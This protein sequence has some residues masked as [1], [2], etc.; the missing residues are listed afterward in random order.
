VVLFACIVVSGC[1]FAANDDLVSVAGS[2]LLK[3]KPVESGTIEFKYA[4][5]MTPPV[6]TL[7]ENGEFAT[8]L[9][10]G[11]T[12]V[13]ISSTVK[14]GERAEYYGAEDSPI[15]EVTKEQIPAK[16]NTRSQLTLEVSD[17]PIEAIL[18]DLKTR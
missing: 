16:Y 2:V 7:I 9:S 14:V 11:T 1:G 5:G 12:K 3:G 8:R 13:V 6:I 17:R 15:Y 18:Y 4:D 10:S